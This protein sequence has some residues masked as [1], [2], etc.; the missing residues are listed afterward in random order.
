[1]I[2]NKIRM[3]IKDRSPVMLRS[4]RIEMYWDGASKPAVSVPLGDFFGVGLGQTT[5]FENDF[6]SNPEGRSFNCFIPMPFHKSAKITITNDADEDLSHIFYN[7]NYQL[8][9]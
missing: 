1:G 5:S 3:T 6:F 4:L 9:E 7:V 8:M 2:V